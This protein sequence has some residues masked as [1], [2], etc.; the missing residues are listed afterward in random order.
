MVA[1]AV[2]LH[3]DG[4]LAYLA[5]D[6]HGEEPFLAHLFEQFLIVSLAVTNHGSED[7]Y[8]VPLE[9]LDDQRHNLVAGV[10]DHRLAGDIA[11][12]RP[13]TGVEQAQEIVD[14]GGGAYGGARIAVDRL[15]FYGYD[16]R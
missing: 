9:T 5:I 8:L 10:L 7:I 3:P 1:V 11:Y 16:G 4:E 14:L 2:Y 6:P 12:R 15:L 13:G